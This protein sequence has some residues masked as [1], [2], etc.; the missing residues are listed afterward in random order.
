M[1]LIGYTVSV[2]LVF[3][4]FLIFSKEPENDWKET[5]TL[6]VHLTEE[7]NLGEIIEEIKRNGSEKEKEL[8][9]SGLTV[10]GVIDNEDFEYLCKR[11]RSP[12]LDM[13]EAVFM[14]KEIQCIFGRDAP[15]FSGTAP[16]EVIVLPRAYY[17]SYNLP[18]GFLAHMK[19]LVYLDMK[20]VREMETGAL[21]G[22]T[23]KKVIFSDNMILSVSLR[24]D[25]LV[26]EIDASG[27]YKIHSFSFSKTSLREIIV[28]RDE[29][30]EMIDKSSGGS[31]GVTVTYPNTEEWDGF[32]QE[33]RDRGFQGKVKRVSYKE[34]E[35]KELME[36]TLDKDD[37][38]EETYQNSYIK[39]LSGNGM[40]VTGIID[41]EDMRFLCE[42]FKGEVLDLSGAVF[43]GE[44]VKCQLE[45]RG[46][47]K[48]IILPQAQKEYY[49]LS[50][51]FLSNIKELD[52][53]DM[54]SVDY[55]GK[56]TFS[57]SKVN[58]IVFSDSFCLGEG[59]F[60]DMITPIKIDI[61]GVYE[62]ER[63]AFN[64]SSIEMITIMREEP[65]VIKAER[66]IGFELPEYTIIVYPDTEEWDGFE[67]V[68]RENGYTG[69]VRRDPFE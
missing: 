3:L 23:M 10:T 1:I 50:E 45:N 26:R 14:E 24:K 54:S 9:K 35:R 18:Y 5:E 46:K 17:G 22:S 67:E 11:F 39:Y 28:L 6:K 60:K 7:D 66:D 47:I 16:I 19:E 58:K 48:K 44:E 15:P 21:Y 43:I 56:G 31:K 32:E 53:V 33:L 29:P 65:P 57:N 64:N 8:Y 13:S 27:A 59:T 61:S 40:K 51:G 52:S 49:D 12:I 38:L 55:I 42:N 34:W 4:C 68:L 25:S 30:P 37:S 62:I 41:N 20:F 2:T 36:L 69:L 63:T